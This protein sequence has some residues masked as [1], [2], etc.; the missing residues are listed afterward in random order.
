MARHTGGLLVVRFGRDGVARADRPDRLVE[1][2]GARSKGR[3]QL[4]RCGG[5]SVVMR[6]HARHP[7]GNSSVSKGGG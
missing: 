6:R 4:M 7:D 3:I 2:L 5:E 1:A